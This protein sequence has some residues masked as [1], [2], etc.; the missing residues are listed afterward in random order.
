MKRKKKTNTTW[1][2]LTNEQKVNIETSLQQLNEG[3][4]IP[5]KKSNG[6]DYKE[7]WSFPKAK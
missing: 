2:T 7:I 6:K 5:I 3:K 1:G 4:G